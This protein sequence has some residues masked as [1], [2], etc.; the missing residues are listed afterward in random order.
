MGSMDIAS[1]L[2]KCISLI[3]EERDKMNICF[4]SRVL[5]FAEGQTRELDVKTAC[6]RIYKV[7]RQ[8]GHSLEITLTSPIK[9]KLEIAYIEKT[10]QEKITLI[11]KGDQA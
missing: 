5:D 10:L 8:V 6:Q 4:A 2:A 3:K 7:K 9:R 1:I 11:I